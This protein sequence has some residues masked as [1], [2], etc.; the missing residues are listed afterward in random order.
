MFSG[1]HIFGRV[2]HGRID[3][4]Q[5]FFR[6]VPVIAPG[7][8]VPELNFAIE[9]LADDGIFGGRF[10]NALNESQRL[11]RAVEDVGFPADVASGNRIRRLNWNHAASS[12]VNRNLRMTA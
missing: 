9:I 3:E 5:N 7:A 11:I 1:R 8:F 12:R 4:A 6:L 2:E 10:E